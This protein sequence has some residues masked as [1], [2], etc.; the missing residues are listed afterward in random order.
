MLSILIV[1]SSLFG[2]LT[3][4]A[5]TAQHTENSDCPH[6]VFDKP[7]TLSQIA[8]YTP[9]EDSTWQNGTVQFHFCDR[10]A[11]LNLDT[12][13][14]GIVKDGVCEGEG[15][16]YVLCDNDRVEFKL[17]KEG[18]IM[19]ARAYND[20]CL[21][22]FPYNYGR[23]FGEKQAEMHTAISNL[24]GTTS[25]QDEMDVPITAMA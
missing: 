23:A 24:A 2:I 8:V 5:P 7:W 17:T 9:A 3:T 14:F 22:E 11:R 16:G 6:K 18:N 15:G 13:C 1:A 21:G 19:V 12:D 25:T 10:N 20:D 4:A